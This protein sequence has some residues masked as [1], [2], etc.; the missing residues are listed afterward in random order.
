MKQHSLARV[1]EVVE[2]EVI[3]STTVNILDYSQVMATIEIVV[4]DYMNNLNYMEKQ[5]S[6][7]DEQRKEIARLTRLLHKKRVINPDFA[8]TVE[9]ADY[10]HV[11]PSFLTK[12]QGK[13][14]KLGIHFF[15]PEGESIVRWKIS[16]LIEWLTGKQNNSNNVDLKLENLLKRR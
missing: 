6:I 10:L 2:G 15:K 8:T 7:I 4:S 13:T 3:T 9:G 1:N 16:A 12:R 5:L 11:D 14:F